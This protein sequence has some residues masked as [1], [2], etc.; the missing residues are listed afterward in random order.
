[1]KIWRRRRTWGVH[2]D[3]YFL[4]PMSAWARPPPPCKPNLRPPLL[5]PA[6][7]PC[8]TVPCPPRHAMPCHATAVQKTCPVSPKGW[9][10]CLRGS[11]NPC[12]HPG[13]A[14]KEGLRR[15]FYELECSGDGCQGELVGAGQPPP[16]AAVRSSSR[17]S[18]LG[19]ELAACSLQLTAY[20][21]QLAVCSLQLTVI[22]P[23]S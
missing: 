21:S 13:P 19:S 15:S 11:K 8:S 9:C 12:H 16:P 6:L 4:G 5:C 3:Y 20:S 14:E 22:T 10:A 17:L 2:A 7:P 1:M 23:P 18:V